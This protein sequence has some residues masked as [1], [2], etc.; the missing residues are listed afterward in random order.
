M[1]CLVNTAD[2]SELPSQGNSCLLSQAVFAWS[3][4]NLVLPQWKILCF[5]LTISTR[6][7]LN[8]F[9]LSILKQYLLELISLVFWK[10]LIMKDSL[11]MLSYTQYHFLWRLVFGAFGLTHDLF[12]STL[13]YLLS[14]PVTICFKNGPFHYISVKN[15]MR[16]YGQEGFLAWLTWSPDIKVI[17]PTKLVQIIL[18]AWFEYFE[19]LSPRWYNTDCS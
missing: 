6:F 8:A 1:Q 10:E 12:Y 14:S 15:C 4:R 17:N 19:W 3:L 2:G 13:L 18:S 9:S 5:L 7:L 16:I 11:L